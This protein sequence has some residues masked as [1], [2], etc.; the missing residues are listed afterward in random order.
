[1]T[2]RV[3]KRSAVMATYFATLDIW[4]GPHKLNAVW[5]LKALV[6]E[7]VADARGQS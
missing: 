3:T 1:M 2:K 4:D 7:Q 5:W 6:A